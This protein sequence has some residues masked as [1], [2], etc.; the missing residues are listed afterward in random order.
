[1]KKLRKDEMYRMSY[2][3]CCRIFC[4]VSDNNIRIKID[5]NVNISDSLRSCATCSRILTAVH[6][7]GYLRIR[8][9]EKCY[10]LKRGAGTED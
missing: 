9:C 2:T 1:M 4:F 8:Y 3:T 5:M 7:R 10:C 6:K